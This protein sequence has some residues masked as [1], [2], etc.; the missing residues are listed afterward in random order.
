MAI[1][2]FLVAF[3]CLAGAFFEGGSILLLLVFVVGLLGSAAM[4]MKAKPWE[5]AER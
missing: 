2:L 1:L 3:T 5:H 4:F